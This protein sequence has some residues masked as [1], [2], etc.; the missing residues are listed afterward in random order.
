MFIFIINFSDPPPAVPI[1]G[2]DGTKCK[3][4]GNFLS[5]FFTYINVFFIT[6][7]FCKNSICSFFKL[8][9]LFHYFINFPILNWVC[10]SYTE[11]FND[12]SITLWV[13]VIVLFFN[14]KLIKS[15][16]KHFFNL[17]F[18]FFYHVRIVILLPVNQNL[19]KKNLSFLF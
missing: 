4:E 13:I 14:E 1:C 3:K 18:L 7:K 17:S 12:F 6:I 11:T 16:S 5:Q 19:T 15:L 2:F 8:I 9:N 10:Q